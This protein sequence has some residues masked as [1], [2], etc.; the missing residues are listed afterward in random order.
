MRDGANGGGYGEVFYAQSNST[1]I[2]ERGG[3]GGGAEIIYTYRYTVTT[4]MTCIKMCSDMRAILMF[5]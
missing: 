2:S 1:V 3:G 5:H 4:S